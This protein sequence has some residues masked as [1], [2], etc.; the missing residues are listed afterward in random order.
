M[1]PVSAAGTGGDAGPAGGPTGPT[2]AAD[3]E[4]GAADAARSTGRALLG[5]LRR[6]LAR[7][8][9]AARLGAVTLVVLL[10]VGATGT[11]LA[12]G[13]DADPQTAHANARA[14]SDGADAWVWGLHAWSAGLLV[15]LVL[16]HAARAFA[17]GK[18]SSFASRRWLAGAGALAVVVTAF[19]T[20][21]VL[22]WDQQGWEA[23]THVQYGVDVVGLS[24]FDPEVPASAPLDVVFWVHV[25]A[26]PAL[27]AAV[28]AIHLHRP[29]VGGVGR[30]ALRLR[31]LLAAGAPAAAVVAV[32]AAALAVVAP[33]LLGPAPFPRLAVSRPDWPFLWL[34]PL[35]DRWDS[36]GL[37]ALP[38]AVAA[39]AALPS[40]GRRWTRRGRLGL[41]WTAAAAMV[42]LSL[43]GAMP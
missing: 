13:Y 33:P 12:L 22:P 23:L 40:L 42:G 30:H 17:R 32:A 25:L 28:L 20:G 29:R 27:L 15:V 19:F 10:V 36:L 7:P 39:G 18:A 26:V 16:L 21:T 37:W 3:A 43:L 8:P 31:A 41:L 35:Q 4:E 6:V 11:Y 24:L 5:R 9:T 2:G 1:R 38:A 14:R 34:L